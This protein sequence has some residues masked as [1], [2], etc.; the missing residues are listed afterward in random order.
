[1]TGGGYF[2]NA[3]IFLIDLLFGL[4]I[5]AIMLRLIL[6]LVRAD[7]YNPLCRAIVSVTNPALKPMR[8][9][10][11]ALGTIDSASILLM[12]GL[13]L[14]SSYLVF[15]LLGYRPSLN[16][17]F[18]TAIAEL[19]GTGIYIF[20]AAIFIQ[21]V[22]SW[23]APGVYSPVVGIIDSITRPFLRLARRILPSTSVIDFS[24][25]LVIVGLMLGLILIVAPLRDL[26]KALL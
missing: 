10:I 22:F 12:L 4:Y 21:I 1:M 26:A 8:R 11:P 15:S 24:P 2:V 19:I 18:L 13:Q 7:F 9:Y 23:V 25:M 14:L 20:M 5:L 16:C 17:L 6:Q 3:S